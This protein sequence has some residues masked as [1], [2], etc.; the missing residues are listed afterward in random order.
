MRRLMLLVR[1]MTSLLP[2]QWYGPALDKLSAM[3]SHTSRHTKVESTPK[4][5]FHRAFYLPEMVSWA[6]L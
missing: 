3:L 5:A 1:S 4:T 6:I 2:N